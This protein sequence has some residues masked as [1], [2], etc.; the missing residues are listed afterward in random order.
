MIAARQS[1]GSIPRSL[2]TRRDRVQLAC[3]FLLCL[4][5]L[6]KFSDWHDLVKSDNHDEVRFLPCPP[7]VLVPDR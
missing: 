5:E 2:L 4:T 1:R 7:L 3:R 6:A